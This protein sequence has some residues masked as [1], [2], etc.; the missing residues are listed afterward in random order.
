MANHVRDGNA[1]IF[2]QQLLRCYTLFHSTYGSSMWTSSSMTMANSCLVL[3][4]QAAYS[5]MVPENTCHFDN[6]R[7]LAN[8]PNHK[9]LVT[10]AVAI[11][12]V[13]FTAAAAFCGATLPRPPAAREQ[14]Q[15][16]R[17]STGQ[18]EPPLHNFT[19]CCGDYSHN[20]AT[21]PKPRCID[22]LFASMTDR[23]ASTRVIPRNTAAS[24]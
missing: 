9:T 19:G 2:Q 5:S 15:R 10:N 23:A 4:L 11:Q 1:D 6:G 8:T 13:L 7:S 16:D 18:S 20:N 3:I 22:M 17:R 24:M 21:L 12:T 14:L